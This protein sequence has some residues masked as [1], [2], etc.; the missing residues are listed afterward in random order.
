[1]ARR[2]FKLKRSS[3][4]DHEVYDAGGGEC[5][6]T[7][8]HAELTEYARVNFGAGNPIRKAKQDCG[9]YA[10]LKR[11]ALLLMEKTNSADGSKPRLRFDEAFLRVCQTAEGAPLYALMREDLGLPK[12]EDGDD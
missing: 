9:A 5:L 6:G 2:K 1:M 11:D 7:L 10:H 4:G 3:G 12:R 8:D